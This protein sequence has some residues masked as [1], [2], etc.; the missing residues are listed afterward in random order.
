MD[1]SCC[2]WESRRKQKRIKN[3]EEDEEKEKQIQKEK[4]RKK[5]PEEQG[6][7]FHPPPPNLPIYF[8]FRHRPTLHTAAFIRCKTQECRLSLYPL[9][10][11][12]SSQKA[13][14]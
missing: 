1:L 6:C 12:T 2:I 3:K 10:T 5:C 11:L 4:R 13:S 14:Q 9:V 7:I 8:V